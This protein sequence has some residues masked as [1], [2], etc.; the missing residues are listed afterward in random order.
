MKNLSDC[1]DLPY[2]LTSLLM[3]GIHTAEI[4][5][6]SWVIKLVKGFEVFKVV[7]MKNAIFWDFAPCRSCEL[8]RRFGGT[9]R[10]HLQ[11]RK[12]R[13]PG[14]SVSRWQQTESPIKKPSNIR[15]EGEREGGRGPCG[16][17][18]ERREVGSVERVDRK[19]SR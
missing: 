18:K 16:K 4:S 3:R 12:I 10:L 17:S 9:C 6:L 15:T 11:G 1:T 7:I 19:A 5:K 13:E 2:E 8:N 14:T